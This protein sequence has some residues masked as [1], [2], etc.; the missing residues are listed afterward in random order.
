MKKQLFKILVFSFILAACEDKIEVELDEGT[1]QLAVD[2]FINNKSNTHKIRLTKT[3]GYFVN[4]A[5]P[6]ALGATVTVT[7]NKK[8]KVFNFIDN[9]KNGNYICTTAAGDTLGIIGNEY[10][11]SIN[12]DGQNFTATSSMYPAPP[13]DSIPYIYKEKDMGAGVQKSGYYASFYAK[14]FAGMTNFYWIKTIRNDT[15]NTNP[16]NINIA[17]DAAF[18][19][20]ADGLTFILPIRESIT[21]RPFHKNDTLSVEIHAINE[22]TLNY[23]LEV[24][25]Q[26]TNSGLFATPP[27]NVRT[28]IKNL[29][30][31]S[32]ITVVGFFNIGA[33]SVAGIRIK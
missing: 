8:N 9:D 21:Q 13:I 17:W 29:N 5:S 6:A 27:A 10:T 20:G 23:L 15:L 3:S 16:S 33:A 19:P 32:K 1:S 26:T 24:R 7:D 2:A 4:S 11:L 18:G 30:S 25:T 22:E 14:D 28:N 12:Y 31:N